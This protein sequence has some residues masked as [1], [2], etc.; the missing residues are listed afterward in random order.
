MER[1]YKRLWEQL[2][3][4]ARV[5]QKGEMATCIPLEAHMKALEVLEDHYVEIEKSKEKRRDINGGNSR[6]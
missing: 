6:L 3:Q 2:K 1:N 5:M 4:D